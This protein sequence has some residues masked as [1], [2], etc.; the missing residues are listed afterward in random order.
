MR[1]PIRLLT[2]VGQWLS[3]RDAALATAPERG[4]HDIA[5]DA[6]SE[7]SLAV[8]PARF[9]VGCSPGV[10]TAADRMLAIAEDLDGSKAAR[11]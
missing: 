8:G 3:C 7:N 11:A 2:R 6:H 1:K 4:G 10:G 5:I 9:N